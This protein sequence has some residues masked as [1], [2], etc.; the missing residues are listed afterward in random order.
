MTGGG[1]W[2][3]LARRTRAAQRATQ[4]RGSGRGRAQ[5][6]RPGMLRAATSNRQPTGPAAST[7]ETT[8]ETTMPDSPAADAY[9]AAIY[10]QANQRLGHTIHTIMRSIFDDDSFPWRRPDTRQTIADALR[11]IPPDT[12]LPDAI[13]RAICAV[14]AGRDFPHNPDI[15][16]QA[17]DRRLADAGPHGDQPGAQTSW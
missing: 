2:R 6:D 5:P 9:L 15:V 3:R 1:E 14:Y 7:T 12:D 17:V 11:D 16:R 4:R 13:A 10:D 8:K